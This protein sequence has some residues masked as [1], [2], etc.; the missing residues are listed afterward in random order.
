MISFDAPAQMSSANL[1]T[2]STTPRPRH[3]RHALTSTCMINMLA[4]RTTAAQPA[5]GAAASIRSSR[6]ALTCASTRRGTG[7]ALSPNPLFP[8]AGATPPPARRPSPATALSRSGRGPT[9]PAAGCPGRPGTDPASSFSVPCFA[10]RAMCTVDRSTRN[11]SAASRCPLPG[12]Q[13]NEDLV[14]LA[15]RQPPP[16]PPPH[17]GIGHHPQPPARSGAPRGPDRPRRMV[18]AWFRSGGGGPTESADPP[19]WGPCS[20]RAYGSGSGASWAPISFSGRDGRVDVR[21]AVWRNR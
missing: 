7:P 13:P 12:Q 2:L 17:S 14:L 18:A 6:L 16:A 5:G 15:R 1:T 10:L 4:R 20:W 11:R 19:P 21:R 8:R 9:P 3:R